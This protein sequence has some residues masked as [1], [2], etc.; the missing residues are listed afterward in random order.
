MVA[1]SSIS[2]D[3]IAA[4]PTG[5]AQGGSAMSEDERSEHE[6]SEQDPT[7]DVEVADEDATEVRG[8]LGG[9]E[10]GWPGFGRVN[11]IEAR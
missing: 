9:G 5:L 6:G 10:G 7:V 11:K 1:G 8:G 2:Y 3:V 4:R